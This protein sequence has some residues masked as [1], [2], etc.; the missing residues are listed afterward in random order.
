MSETF[1]D[2][3]VRGLRGLLVKAARARRLLTYDEVVRPP[4]G[5]WTAESRDAEFKALFAALGRIGRENLCNKEPLLPALV[6]GKNTKLPGLGFF[7]KF[8]QKARGDAEMR[9]HHAALLDAV[10]KFKWPD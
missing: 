8:C 6:V 4:V 5:T 7:Q 2:A 9:S 3:E 10:W 1:D